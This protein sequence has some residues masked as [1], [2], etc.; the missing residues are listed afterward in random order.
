MT[1]DKP[2]K[3]I[4]QSRAEQSR[5]LRIGLIDVDGH[6]FPNLPLM[7]LSAWHKAQGDSV[8]W[9]NPLFSGH[10]DRVY[11]SKVFSF[12]QDYPYSI[13]ADEVI[14]GGSGYAIELENG[15]EH[16]LTERNNVLPDEIEHIYPD[17][18]IYP[19]LTK[20]T[21]YGFLSRGC[22]RGCSFCHVAAKEGKCA[23]K[24][25]DLSEFWHGQ[26]N[27]ML[28][29]PNIT[30]VPEWEDLFGQLIESN[31]YIDISQG[32]DARLLTEKKAEM[33]KQMKIKM[34]HLAWDRYEDGK[35]I[36]PK[37]QTLR[38]IT[39]WGRH[40]CSVFV[41]VNFDT[42]TE[43]DLERIY[44]IRDIG[45]QPYV[46]VYDKEHTTMNDT[47]RQIARWVNAVPIFRTVKTFEEYK[48]V[49]RSY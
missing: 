38:E 11:K 28:L 45:F 42:T 36:V 4:S 26:K 20:E 6:N 24:V 29:D 17:Y 7:K 25:A 46:M 2:N 14:S 8:E 33:L 35:V 37:L 3:T 15:R 44:A 9:Y 48:N 18:S 12:T 30:A 13:D 43:Q 39:G 31:S 49:R 19:E 34:V 5:A 41:L 16:F 32:I 47:C 27:I 40:K 1:R 23:R 22:P 10:M 21:A